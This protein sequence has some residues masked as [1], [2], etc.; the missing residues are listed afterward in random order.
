M[1]MYSYTHVCLMSFLSEP[2]M[3]PN[4]LMIKRGSI[5][6]RSTFNFEARLLWVG[7]DDSL[8]CW[9]LLNRI[10]ICV[11]LFCRRDLNFEVV[12]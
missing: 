8:V 1:H 4:V 6:Q 10:P 11:G 9:V 7:N 2:Y 12:Y 3:I 5:C